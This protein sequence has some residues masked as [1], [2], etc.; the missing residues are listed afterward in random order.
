[1]E[2]TTDKARKRIQRDSKFSIGRSPKDESRV[3]NELKI[4]ISDL[5]ERFDL[6][7]KVIEYLVREV[8][9]E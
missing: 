9:E 6:M 8:E 3:I 5:E 2:S 7:E 4:Q 1:M